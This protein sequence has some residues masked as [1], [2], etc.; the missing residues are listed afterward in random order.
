MKKILVIIDVQNDFVTGSL[1]NEEAQKK[2]PNIVKKIR[3][4]NGDAIIATRDTH[5]TEYLSTKEGEKL[6]VKHCIEYTEGWHIEP[7]VQSA[8]FDASRLKGLPVY[9]IDKP[10]FGSV[11]LAE[12]IYYIAYYRVRN[13]CSY[14]VFLLP[15]L[16][17]ELYLF[18]LRRK[19]K[20]FHKT[21]F[22][23]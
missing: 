6:P 13:I 9:Y 3:E 21:I 2:V 11:E 19:N 12:K 5:G 4:F 7:T 17:I 18:F 1:G 20:Y 22:L 15:Y 16:C 14:Q 8:L 23:V 10:T